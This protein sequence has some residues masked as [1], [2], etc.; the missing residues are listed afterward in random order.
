MNR[1]SDNGLP[2]PSTGRQDRHRPAT[3]RAPSAAPEIHTPVDEAAPLD[4]GEHLPPRGMHHYSRGRGHEVGFGCLVFFLVGCIGIAVVLVALSFRS[5]GDD[6]MPEGAMAPGAEAV[7]GSTAA[8][9]PASAD[10]GGA[11]DGAG[12]GDGGGAVS[13]E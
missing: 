1:H 10:G 12:G 2:P 9:A 5:T 8:S 4:H 7:D 6:F 3:P 11:G 13:P